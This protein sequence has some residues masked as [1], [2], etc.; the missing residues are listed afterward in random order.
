MT[1]RD[2]TSNRQRDFVAPPRSGIVV[3]PQNSAELPSVS[4]RIWIGADGNLSVVMADGV[5]SGALLIPG[6]LA[7]TMLYIQARQ[8]T[9]LGT[10]I[11]SGSIIA[12]W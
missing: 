6:V 9:A 10:T 2:P 12:F 5:S 3:T 7:G 8:I 4:K 11:A 1:A